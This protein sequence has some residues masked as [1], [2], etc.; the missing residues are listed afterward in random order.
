[1][2]LFAPAWM[3]KESIRSLSSRESST[4]STT[5]LSPRFMSQIVITIKNA[6][7]AT[8]MP[9]PQETERYAP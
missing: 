1:M 5:A 7:R 2:V 4:L 3:R 8:I 9:V 6:E